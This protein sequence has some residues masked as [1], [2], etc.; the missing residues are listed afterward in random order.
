[1]STILA[2]ETSSELASVALL[3]DGRCYSREAQGTQTHSQTILPMIQDL[4]AERGKSIAQC[5]AI[6]YGSGPGSFTG[7]RTACGIVQGLAYGADRPVIPVVTLEAMAQCCKKKNGADEVVAILDARMGEVYWAQYRY[8]GGEWHVVVPPTLSLP[9]V[10][11]PVGKPTACG[12]GLLAY[13]GHIQSDLFSRLDRNAALLPH[14]VE[15]AELAEYRLAAGRTVRAHDAQPFYL[16]NKVALTTAE[17][18]L[19]S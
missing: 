12:N 16:R 19:R 6:A 13:E 18:A 10:I 5:D 3:I 7:V 4:L 2:L 8:A 11:V 17:R 9:N 15:I 1:M 14:A